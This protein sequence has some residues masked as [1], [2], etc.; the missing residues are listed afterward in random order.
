M[1]NCALLAIGVGQDVSSVREAN[2]SDRE[3]TEVF[4]GKSKSK[5]GWIREEAAFGCLG[6]LVLADS[7]DRGL[8][9]VSCM[10]DLAAHGASLVCG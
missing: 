8:P 2:W 9:G 5:V 7:S 6:G 10:S 4:A 1:P 3:G